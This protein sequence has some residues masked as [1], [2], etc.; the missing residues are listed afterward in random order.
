METVSVTT[1]SPG[2]TIKPSPKWNRA[3][4]IA[5]DHRKKGRKEDRRHAPNPISCKPLKQCGYRQQA[6]PVDVTVA[7]HGSQRYT[8]NQETKRLRQSNAEQ[9]ITPHAAQRLRWA[10]EP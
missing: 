3:L 2:E 8:F 4:G 6:K 9:G 7:N 10:S 1:P 5:K